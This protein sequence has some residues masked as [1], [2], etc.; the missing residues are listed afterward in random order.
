[1]VFRWELE[2]L[3]YFSMV[4]IVVDIVEKVDIDVEIDMGGY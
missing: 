2:L 4:D 3:V 1:V